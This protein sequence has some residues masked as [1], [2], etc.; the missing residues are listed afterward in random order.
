MS[1]SRRRHVVYM[2]GYLSPIRRLETNRKIRHR[3]FF[4]FFFFKRVSQSCLLKKPIK[5][6]HKKRRPHWQGE[7]F[8]RVE[9]QNSPTRATLLGQLSIQYRYFLKKDSNRLL[10]KQKVGSARRMTHLTGSRFLGQ[11]LGRANFSPNKDLGSL[12]QGKINRACVSA[13]LDNKGKGER[14]WLGQRGE[15]ASPSNVYN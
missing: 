4:L 15:R 9:G 3:V 1:Y 11:Y 6:D 2:L 10:G 12:G 5:Q 8:F 7:K 13:V 14:C